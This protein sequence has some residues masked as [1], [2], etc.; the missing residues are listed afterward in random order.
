MIVYLKFYINSLLNLLQQ[1]C[2]YPVVGNRLIDAGDDHHY[3]SDHIPIFHACSHASPRGGEQMLISS[4]ML[5]AP[6]ML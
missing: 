2:C 3:S 6:Q 1:L 4:Q 5:P